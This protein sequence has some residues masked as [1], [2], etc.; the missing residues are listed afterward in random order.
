M[1]DHA[2]CTD[3]EAVAVIIEQ[4]IEE[5]SGQHIGCC[6]SAHRKIDFAKHVVSYLIACIGATTVL[7][8]QQR[9]HTAPIKLYFPAGAAVGGM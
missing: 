8:L 2:E 4:H 6:G 7:I 5:R 1:Q 3:Y 9:K